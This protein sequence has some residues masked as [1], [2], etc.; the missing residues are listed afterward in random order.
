MGVQ[1]RPILREDDDSLRG[2]TSRLTSSRLLRLL[3]PFDFFAF[4][5][6]QKVVS[7][8][9][10]PNYFNIVHVMLKIILP[11]QYKGVYVMLKTF[12]I[13]EGI[14]KDFT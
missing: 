6:L 14:L 2:L 7:K 13:S 8:H 4:H 11:L 10:E 5:Y 9:N 1:Q 12:S 3:R